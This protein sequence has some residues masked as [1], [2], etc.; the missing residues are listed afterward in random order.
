MKE[1]GYII[2]KK[3]VFNKIIG[4]SG[5]E[6]EFAGF[7]ENCEDVISY[8]KNYMAVNFRLDYVNAK[9]DISNY[10]PD[11]VVRISDSQYFIVETK[12]QED[13]DVPLKMERLKQW[14]V[15][16][17]KEQKEKAFDYVFVDEENFQKFKPATFD[18]LARTFRQYK[19]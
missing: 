13:L 12:G 15:D 17:N 9:G 1:Q 8:V 16:I 2:P 7:L 3:S 6:L 19:D 5:L 4:D 10:Y 11:F 18:Q 14:C